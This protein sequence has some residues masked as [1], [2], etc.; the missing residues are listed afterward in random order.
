MNTSPAMTGD[1]A[2]GRSISVINVLLPRNSNL[3]IAHA[4]ATPNTRL[5]GT[6]MAATDSSRP[7]RARPPWDASAAAMSRQSPVLKCVDAEHEGE[8]QD[9]H[10]HGDGRCARIIILLQ[11]AD[12]QQR[13]DLGF[14]R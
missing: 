13:C 2:N 8:G 3:A 9:Q 14:H 4:A 7:A 11:F 12:D 1:T 6:A 5:H 10:H